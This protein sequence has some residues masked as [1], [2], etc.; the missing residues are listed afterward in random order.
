MEK[1]LR[2][3]KPKR[4]LREWS[5]D[6]HKKLNRDTERIE[7]WSRIS[8]MIYAY[9][10]SIPYSFWIWL[11]HLYFRKHRLSRRLETREHCFLVL[12]AKSSIFFL[13]LMAKATSW[14]D[15]LTYPIQPNTN[16]NTQAA[17][18]VAYQYNIGR[19]KLLLSPCLFDPVKS[20]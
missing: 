20:E 17:T 12:S 7:Q 2:T 10:R 5:I 19:S 4:I 11:H 15:A 6:V 16:Q 1:C 13:W 3:T 8:M 14:H 18:L 9:K